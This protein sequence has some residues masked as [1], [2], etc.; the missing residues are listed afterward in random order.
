MN[1]LAARATEAKDQDMVLR[2]GRITQAFA[3]G[4]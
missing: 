4:R 3:D 2:D 1:T